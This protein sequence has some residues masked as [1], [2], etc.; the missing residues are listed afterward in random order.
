MNV[1]VSREA[2]GGVDVRS[3]KGI[4]LA[5]AGPRRCTYNQRRRRP[6]YIT[7]ADAPGANCARR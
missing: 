4:E 2:E 7:V 3:T 6:G 5:G 1:R